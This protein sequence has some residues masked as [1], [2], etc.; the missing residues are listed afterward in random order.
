MVKYTVRRI[1][2]ITLTF[3]VSHFQEAIDIIHGVTDDQADRMAKNLG[4][5]GDALKQVTIGYLT[6]ESF[7][8][9]YVHGEGTTPGTI[10]VQ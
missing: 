3:Y 5:E 8:L 7:S 4:F 1:H 6:V 10:M 9:V 2:N